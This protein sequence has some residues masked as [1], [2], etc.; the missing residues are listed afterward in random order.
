MS[1]AQ[2]AEGEKFK[3]EGSLMRKHLFLRILAVGTFLL[4]FSASSVLADEFGSIRG[5][6][7]DSTGAVIAGVKLTATNV[8]TN[9]SVS[10]TSKADGSY[11]FLQVQTPGSY[12]VT[13]TQAGFKSYEANDL[14]LGL[15][16]IFVLNIT[17]ELGAV[18][19]QVTVEAAP[20]QVEKTSIESGATLNANQL[21]DIPLNGRNWV[22]L[23][24]TLPG[25]VATADSRGNFATNGS[26]PDQNSYLINGID[27]NDLPLN[28]ALVVPSPDAI[29]EVRMITN[30]INPEY[31]RNSG[32]IMDAVTKSG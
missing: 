30:T 21:V 31:G 10:A 22:Q 11:E 29:A 16:Q 1:R 8:A 17:L 28:T 32:A 6:V 3:L 15:N 2:F 4:L 25:V 13:T 27:S 9:I 23:Q 26:Q 5:V 19:Q 18:S 24:Q 12:K 20:V 7:S 14:H